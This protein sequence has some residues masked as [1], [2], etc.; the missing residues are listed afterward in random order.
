MMKKTIF[1]GVLLSCFF[2]SNAYPLDSK[3]E[4]DFSI[5][6]NTYQ[7]GSYSDTVILFERFVRIFT[8][9]PRRFD[10]L[11]YIGKA[12]FNLNKFQ[13]SETA[14]K[15][16]VNSDDSQAFKI[17]DQA[18]LWLGKICLKEKKFEEA[19]VYFKYLVNEFN[20]SPV[21]EK[22]LLYWIELE[23]EDGK[24]LW[25]RD[26]FIENLNVFSDKELLERIA[27]KIVRF[28]YN[29]RKFN[30]LRDFIF[31]LKSKVSNL[32]SPYFEFYLAESLYYCGDF[33]KSKEYYLL[34]VNKVTDSYAKDAIYLALGW[35]HIKLKDFRL[36]ADYFGRISKDNFNLYISLNLGVIELQFYTQNYDK[37]LEL[38]DALLKD[39]S[40]NTGVFYKLNLTRARCYLELGKI[41]EAIAA[42]QEIIS[43]KSLLKDKN[44]LLDAFMIYADC[45]SKDGQTKGAIDVL[46]GA[47]EVFNRKDLKIEILFKLADFYETS[48]NLKDSQKTYDSILVLTKDEAVVNHALYEKA[49]NYLNMNLFDKAIKELGALR[50]STSD[51]DLKNNIDYNLALAYYGKGDFELSLSMLNKLIDNQDNFYLNLKS[52]YL[53][54]RNIYALDDY[55]GALIEFNSINKSSN[56][57]EITIKSEIGAANC[58]RMLGKA[59]EAIKKLESLRSRYPNISFTPEILFN[60]AD[61]YYSVD[62]FDMALRYLDNILSLYSDFEEIDKVCYLYA[63]ISL[64]KNN[65][66]EA[67]DFFIKSFDRCQEENFCFTI[68]SEVASLEQTNPMAMLEYYMK[69]N[70]RYPANYNCY[71]QMAKT[72]KK[73]G[74][75]NEALDLLVLSENKINSKKRDEFFYYAGQ[76]FE[77]EARVET[78]IRY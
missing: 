77:E 21:K 54:A 37:A 8:D 70:K 75:L 73:M 67:K 36:A 27:F 1:F 41:K 43:D 56:D 16:I 13:E 66:L 40:I 4:D 64:K 6:L 5:A 7:N 51:Q 33:S 25:A 10:A 2:I 20:N 48:N 52:R 47:L 19:R 61:S 62:Q 22:T 65:I 23:L 11:L 57:K 60:L 32:D 49:L 12:N 39:K 15:K 45:L 31:L 46:I 44:E 28:L 38:I 74:K 26:V 30:E 42:A 69:F 17:K 72:Y 9:S 50:E 53:L 29:A 59:T 76:F 14:F 68:I 71:I 35:I 34:A 24:L 3:I 63:G 78:A 55:E 18:I 58:L